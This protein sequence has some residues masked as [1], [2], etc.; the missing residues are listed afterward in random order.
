MAI[1][2]LAGGL[3]LPWFAQHQSGF[4]GPA[5]GYVVGFLIA[6]P[7]VGW[8]AQRNGDRSVLRTT[9]TMLLGTSLIY[10]VPWLASSLHLSLAKG[11]SLGVQPFLVGDMLKILLAAGLLPTAWGVLSPDSSWHLVDTAGES[12]KVP[13]L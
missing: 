5:F 2:L 6:A 1:Y 12:A 11:L 8:L 13:V 9:A 7:V 10:A 3:G 4:G